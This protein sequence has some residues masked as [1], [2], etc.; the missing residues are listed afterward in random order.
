[1]FFFFFSG[2]WIL[3]VICFPY[4]TGK[5]HIENG[6]P[7]NE[8]DDDTG[9]Y[10]KLKYT[11]VVTLIVTYYNNLLTNNIRR[12]YIYSKLFIHCYKYS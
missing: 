10:F 11:C 2:H 3:A 1:M 8:P 5:V 6:T 4:L 9:K 12:K 7:S